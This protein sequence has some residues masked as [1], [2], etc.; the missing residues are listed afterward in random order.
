MHEEVDIKWIKKKPRTKSFIWTARV[1]QEGHEE[2]CQFW[3]GKATVQ[4]EDS[5]GNKSFVPLVP[6]HDP[7][8]TVYEDVNHLLL[9]ENNGSQGPRRKLDMVVS[10]QPKASEEVHEN[11]IDDDNQHA[12][13]TLLGPE[14]VSRTFSE[15][16]EACQ[17]PNCSAI[18]NS[19][20]RLSH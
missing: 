10:S 13:F 12:P 11:E 19:Q 8:L 4:L 15:I 16:Q 9:N 14:D 1:L 20:V 6:S 7:E 2:F 5:A 17:L 3:L 18:A